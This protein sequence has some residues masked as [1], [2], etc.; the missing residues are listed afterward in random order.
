MKIR[1]MR[2]TDRDA[3]V[4][5]WHITKRAAY[6]YLELEQGRSLEQDRTFFEERVAAR[7]E[8]WLA[9]RGDEIT[10][11]I[12][13]HE[14]YIDRLYVH[15]RHQRQGVGSRLLERALSLSSSGL[16]L[17]THQKNLEACAFYEK[18]GF[19]AVRYGLSPAPENEPDVEYHWR[20]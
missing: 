1:R 7:C 5:L 2:E 4:L 10:G 20:P 19:R 15:P 17:H 6:P 18:H 13:L 3:V 14:S 16:E 12:A 11:F 8:V 9:D